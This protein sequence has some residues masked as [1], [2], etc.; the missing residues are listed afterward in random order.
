MLIIR[1]E[2]M[3]AF[4]QIDFPAF[5]KEMADHI[6]KH[7]PGHSKVFGDKA[8]SNVI[9]QGFERAKAYDFTTRHE[10]CLFIDMMIMLGSGF[11]TD[12]QMT[13]AGDILN[14]KNFSDPTIKIERLYDRAMVYLDHVVG[15]DAVFPVGPLRKMF[16]YPAKKLQNLSESDMDNGILF[17]FKNIWPQKFRVVGEEQLRVLIQHNMALI[18]DYGISGIPAICFFLILMYLLGHR[19][20]MDSM[21]ELSMAGFNDD[22]VEGPAQKF[23][24]LYAAFMTTL[25]EM[26]K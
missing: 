7:F 21:Y 12:P 14:D 2:Q 11:D 8:I 9:H 6:S 24:H 22:K 13:W 10:V 3:K 26:L 1:K 23:E 15:T 19:F 20:Y 25:N 4:D 17:E 5:S 16:E 18:G